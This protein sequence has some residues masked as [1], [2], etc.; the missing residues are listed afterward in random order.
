MTERPSD[1]TDATSDDASTPAHA[2]R[3]APTS[4][5]SPSRSSGSQGGGTWLRT[6]LLAAPLVVLG[7]VVA[8]QSPDPV[9]GDA[10]S[11]ANTP[12]AAAD[13]VVKS[14][15]A[16]EELPRV[17]EIVAALWQGKPVA[18]LGDVPGRLTEA[19][20]P[21]YVA[22]REGGSRKAQLWQTDDGTV[23]E[24]LAEAL[25]RLRKDVG[26]A[27]DRIDTLS[28]DLTH[29]YREVEF[30]YLRSK[31]YRRSHRGV[32]GVELQHGDDVLR[33]GP[34]R[35]IDSNRGPNRIRQ[36][37]RDQHKLTDEQTT[38]GEVTY[39]IFESDELHV[40]LG[41]A[42]VAKRLF[43][44]NELVDVSEVSAAS[45]EAWSQRSIDWLRN[46][47]HDDGR[48][49]YI[50]WPSPTR[51]A[52]PG[53]NNMIRQWMATVA[54]GKWAADRQDQATWD[55]AERNIDYNLSRFYHAEGELGMIEWQG[56]VKLGAM[57]LAT[58]AI[59]EH[60]NR[61]KWAE[62]EAALRRSIDSLWNDDG[63]FTTFLK[64]KGRNDNTNFYPGEALL[65]WAVLYDQER[66]PELLDKFMKSFRYYRAWHLEPD[67]RN[68]AFTPWHTQAY[69]LVWSHTKDTELRDFIYEMN[70]WLIEIQQ[71][72]DAN[73]PDEK[74][75][76][77][78]RK[79]PF[80]PP[81]ASSTGVYI[82]G[83]IDAFRMARELGDTDRAQ[84]YRLALVRG[85][86]SQLQLQFADEVDMFYV[87]EA[88]R[89]FVRGGVRTT[90]FNNEIRCDNVQH[91]LM[92]I[93]KVLRAFGPEDFAHP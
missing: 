44:G 91:P 78:D 31:E 61:A 24:Q 83:L 73:H 47:V 21:I 92:G 90:V 52:G 28:I 15:L 34:S 20:L 82:E 70:D 40:T 79:R 18:D 51:E 3:P 30:D 89:R 19:A 4:P 59:V 25:G 12:A 76:F 49:T 46:N 93:L 23:V 68:P 72:D 2:T 36:V 84:A 53:K 86:R 67:N 13:T 62:A 37:F 29:S 88:K 55:L 80:G 77:Y 65:L 6:A 74:G 75:R 71:W 58:M 26:S 1:S 27:A 8:T 48:M 54:L 38:S 7:Y 43:R 64:P 69:Y 56:K 32:Y 16:D 9:E 57:A 85:M 66:D 42:P 60:P 41:Q 17:A 87:S 81:H 11:Q 63:S 22:A 5:D 45:M 14:P 39:R 33:Y 50:F 35:V 10:T